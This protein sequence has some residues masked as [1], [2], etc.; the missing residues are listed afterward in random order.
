MDLADTEKCEKKVFDGEEN[1]F[2]HRHFKKSESR[3]DLLIMTRPTLDSREGLT[4]IMQ[5][6]TR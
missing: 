4:R 6:E 2:P 5:R 1:T 3:V